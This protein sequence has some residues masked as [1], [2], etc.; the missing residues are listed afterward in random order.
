M[1][2]GHLRENALLALKFTHVAVIKWLSLVGA[3][4][5]LPLQ[6]INSAA[7]N[8]FVI[9]LVKVSTGIF[10]KSVQISVNKDKRATIRSVVFEQRV[11]I[12]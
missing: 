12:A 9:G 4:H 3:G 1:A 2:V 5:Y 7:K 6:N 8:C 10:L 11:L